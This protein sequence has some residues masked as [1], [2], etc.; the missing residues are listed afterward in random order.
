MIPE[1]TLAAFLND[2]LETNAREGVA[3]ELA[4]DPDALDFVLQQRQIDQALRSLLSPPSRKTHLRDSIRAAVTGMPREQLRAQVRAWTIGQEPTATRRNLPNAAATGKLQIPA[5]EPWRKFWATLA[6]MSGLARGLM[7]AATGLVVIGL[8]LWLGAFRH[9]DR[10]PRVIGVLVEVVGV[11]TVQRPGHSQAI[12]AKPGISF[13]DGDRLETGD[14]DRAEIR[15][16]DGTKLRLAFNTSIELPLA[17]HPQL[18]ATNAL[19]RPAE[20]RLLKGQVWTK[21]AKLTNAPTYAIRTEAATAIARGT[22]FGVKLQRVEVPG[23]DAS[24]AIRHSPLATPDSPFAAVLTVTEGIVDFTNAHGSVRATA[25]TES[26]ARADSAP[27]EPRRLPTLPTVGVD[28][29]H[30]FPILTARLT[31]SVAAG[32]LVPG[33]GWIGLVL[34]DLTNAAVANPRPGA[35]PAS[36]VRVA[37]VEGGSPADLAGIRP[38]DQVLDVNGQPTARAGDVERFLLGSPETRLNLRLRR[39]GEEVPVE[40]TVARRSSH[41]PGP[42][43]TS[44]QLEQLADATRR[45]LTG[46][47]SVAE[48]DIG[49]VRDSVVRAPAENNLGV[50][51]ETEDLLGPAIRAYGRAVRADPTV[52]LYRVNL[53]LALRLIGS[54]E[55]AAEELG[56]A[57]RLAPASTLARQRFAEIQSLLGRDS[58]ALA[59]TEAALGEDPQSHGLWELKAQLLWRQRRFQEARDAA[60]RAI[61][62]ERNCPVAHAYLGGVLQEEGQMDAAARAYEQTLSLAPFEPSIHFRLGEVCLARGEPQKAEQHF[63]RAA[64]LRPDSAE[65]HLQLGLVL[66]GRGEFAEAER[67]LQRARELLPDSSGIQN[68]LGEVLRHQGR[69]DEALR[70]FQR[71]IELDPENMAPLNNLGILHAMRREF[72]DAERAFRTVAERDSGQRTAALLNLAMALASQHKLDDAES[73]YRQALTTDPNAPMVWNHFAF[74]LAEQR[75][76]LGEALDLARRA[77]EASPDSPGFLDTLGWVLAQRGEFDAAEQTLNRAL[78]LGGAGPDGPEIRDHLRRVREMKTRLPSPSNVP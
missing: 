20:V 60:S 37:Q 69:L 29:D 12:D 8:A 72:A 66:I 56:A 51:W 54:Y 13:L 33:G 36:E 45:L 44:R 10:T 68:N 58:H 11:P 6:S 64:L 30:D 73:A 49:L 76:H 71:A 67:V 18:P 19:L 16:R 7:A 65:A 25:M 46:D 35:A 63:R 61:E 48:R 50:R 70:C 41:V 2:A 75:R 39:G 14:A 31:G 77:V 28:S 38:G 26:T 43:L 3:A 32:R 24:P 62:L 47:A 53:G 59:L 78:Q 74:F 4:R 9:Q 52:P 21:V 42:A 22:E 27:T 5:G 57:V 1:D 40:V 55:R 17:G 34:L 15:F 23:A